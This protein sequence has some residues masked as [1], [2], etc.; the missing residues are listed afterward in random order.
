[1]THLVYF[2]R[3]EITTVTVRTGVQRVLLLLSRAAQQRVMTEQEGRGKRYNRKRKRW[4][5][6]RKTLTDREADIQYSGRGET[7]WGKVRDK[8][9]IHAHT[10]TIY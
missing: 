9:Y 4:R 3:F 5:Q 10:G 2:P 7:E 1:M 8:T 6:E